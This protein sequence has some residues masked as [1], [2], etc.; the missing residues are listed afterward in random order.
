MEVQIW[1]INWISYIGKLHSINYNWR[2]LVQVLNPCP[3]LQ[4]VE[5]SQGTAVGDGIRDIDQE[6][7]VDPASVPRCISLHLKT[8]TL[9][10]FRGQHGEVQLATY[11]LNNARV[12]QTMKICCCDSLKKEREVSLYA[13]RPLLHVNL[14]FMCSSDIR[15][16]P[17][18]INFDNSTTRFVGLNCEP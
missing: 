10:Y 9:W 8:C 16:S 15:R 14:F 1:C 5:L 12:L 18:L 11:I 13:Q 3:N 2:L 6:N 4:N 7:W 17:S